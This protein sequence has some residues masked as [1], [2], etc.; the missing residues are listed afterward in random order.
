MRR[1]YKFRRSD[2]R[3]VVVVLL[4]FSVL[5][6]LGCL[7]KGSKT[8]W[9]GESRSP[10]A[11]MLVTARAFNQSGFGTGWAETTV[12]LNWTTGSQPPI[13]ILAFSEWPAGPDGMKVRMKWLTPKHL[14]LSFIKQPLDFQAVKGD[15]VDISVREVTGISSLDSSKAGADLLRSANKGNESE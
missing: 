10:D 1:G 12:Y 4:A 3:A 15:G 5:P 6:L 7:R 14:E 11:K 2:L 8:I 13:L 9:S